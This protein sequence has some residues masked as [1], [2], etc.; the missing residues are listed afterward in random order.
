MAE[1]KEA[2]VLAVVAQTQAAAGVDMPKVNE[3]L[4]RFIDMRMFV[5]GSTK[6]R[7][8][9]MY[10]EYEHIK[11]LRPE[12]KLNKDETLSLVTFGANKP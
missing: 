8:E 11:D 3:H 9:S 10:D 2:S 7:T 6:D 1:K 5:Q 12:L 4:T